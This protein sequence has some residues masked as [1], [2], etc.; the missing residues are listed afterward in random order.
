WLRA[1]RR[2]E[3]LVVQADPTGLEPGTY[4]DTVHLSLRGEE[5]PAGRIPVELRVTR[6]GEPEVIAA[7]LPWG[8]GLATRAGQLFQASYGWDPLGL[9]PRPRLLHLPGPGRRTKTA[10]RLPAEAL[11]SPVPSPDGGVY[12][13]ARAREENYLY[14]V[15]PDGRAE[16]I[17]GGFGPAPAYGAATLRDGSVLVADWSGRIQRVDRNGEIEPW[18]EL[19]TGIYQIAVDS[20]AT[21]YAAAHAGHVLRVGPDGTVT[22]LPTGFGRGRLVAITA[23]PAGDVFAAERGG[24]GRVL[25][26]APDGTTEVIA[27]VEGAEFYGLAVEDEFLYALDLAH[28]Q[29]LRF[30]LASAAGVTAA[31][32]S[33][34]DD[35]E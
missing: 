13:L 25:R 3:S 6:H 24:K 28:R 9:R 8:W 33:A 5:S 35:S 31:A 2:G 4:R 32:P 29:L 7:G 30:P 11:Y 22:V 20:A 12:I 14:S 10:V 23:S 34:Q 27:T 19:G 16:L 1:A 15:L 18:T 17:A 21:L 26:I